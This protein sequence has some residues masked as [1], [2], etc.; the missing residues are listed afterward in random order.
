M[1]RMM[2]AMNLKQRDGEC[3]FSY[4][5]RLK[6]AQDSVE[7][8]TWPD[9]RKKAADLFQRITDDKLKD[10][11][12]KKAN[13]NVEKFTVQFI[14]E[15]YQKM[16]AGARES[17]KPVENYGHIDKGVGSINRPNKNNQ[18]NNNDNKPTPRV[19]KAA[20]ETPEKRQ[21]QM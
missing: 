2:T 12:M 6:I 15:P 16:K 10:E 11:L 7:W 5:S 3:L 17:W 8:E 1:K 21:E 14:T 20:E 9:W 18:K 4:M 19:A 13:N